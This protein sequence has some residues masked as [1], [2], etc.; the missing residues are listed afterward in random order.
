MMLRRRPSPRGM[1][2]VTSD[3]V[4]AVQMPRAALARML[5]GARYLR[6]RPNRTKGPCQNKNGIILFLLLG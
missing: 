1:L 4:G 2:A 6:K 3:R 5:N